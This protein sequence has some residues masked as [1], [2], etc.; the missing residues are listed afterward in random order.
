M[1]ARYD[2]RVPAISQKV[3]LVPVRNVRY[4]Y[5]FHLSPTASSCY[6]YNHMRHLISSHLISFFSKTLNSVNYNFQTVKA[7][8]L[9]LV[10]FERSLRE[11]FIPHIVFT[12]LSKNR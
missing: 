11:Y 10:A 4:R 8:K 7:T 12:F 5:Y 1:V 2:V 3:M 9:W 6:T